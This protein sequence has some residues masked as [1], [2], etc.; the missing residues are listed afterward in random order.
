VKVLLV[1][2]AYQQTGGED[3][4]LVSEKDLLT[5]HGHKNEL[6]MV[7]NVNVQGVASKLGA[8]L[9]S[10]WSSTGYESVLTAIYR[11][12]PDVVHVHNF[13][14]L[15]TPS[16]YD[17][18]I[19]AGVPVVQTLHNYRTICPGAL[20]MRNGKI[21]EKCV[22]G[23]P[24]QAIL[25]RCYRNS[26]PGSWAVARMVDLHRKKQTWEYKVDRFIALTLFA[27]QKFVEAGFPEEKIVV[28]SNFCELR[29]VRSEELGQRAGALFVGR[30]SEGKGVTTM[31]TAWHGLNIPLRVAGDG[32]LVKEGIRKYA[33]NVEFLGR[34]TGEQVSQEMDYASFFVMP[35]ECYEG[36]P[37]VLVEAFAHGL[38]V[39]ASCLG[40]MSE[41]V[42][43]GV[44]G[45]HFEPGNP[46]DLAKK[47]QWMS[48]HPEKCRKMGQNARE[49][50]LGQ[51]T[52]EKNYK[53]L[54]DIYEKA[55][56]MHKKRK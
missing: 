12:H 17:S 55:I 39:V 9:H 21:C 52:P 3:S 49:V 11:F 15:L 47:V 36:F 19:D 54:M 6:V 34:L 4:V 22:T 20:L 40:G 27:K 26:I 8:A 50:Y 23:S 25:Y 43:D 46:E 7:T 18:C 24:Y 48:S 1:H 42:E 37:L 32:P 14:P 29:G 28:K 41:I 45:L 31:L 51:Y 10:T 38:P 5:R 44:T 33:G 35:S 16:V 30:L 56:E 53:M 13:F 2:N